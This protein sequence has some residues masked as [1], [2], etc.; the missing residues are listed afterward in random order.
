MYNYS[1]GEFGEFPFKIPAGGPYLL[2]DNWYG[3]ESI[4]II[5]VYGGINGVTEVGSPYFVSHTEPIEAF[6][7]GLLSSIPII[8]VLLCVYMLRLLRRAPTG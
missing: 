5:D 3:S 2:P 7:G 1:G 6:Q 4:Y 8:S